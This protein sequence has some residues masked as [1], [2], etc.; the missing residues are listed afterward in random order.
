MLITKAGVVFRGFTREL[1]EILDA[2]TRL[3]ELYPHDIVITSA[4]EGRHAKNSRHYSFQAVDVRSKYFKKEE[5]QRF[6]SL[7]SAFLGKKY[8]VLLEDAGKP[9][10]HIHVELD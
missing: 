2:L 8:L 3:A 9:N 7:L 4:S 6:M 10:E 5:K 1:V